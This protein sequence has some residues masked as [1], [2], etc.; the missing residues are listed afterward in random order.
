M[1]TKRH[2]LFRSLR[3]HP[4]ILATAP[5]DHAAFDDLTNGT[6]HERAA[7]LWNSDMA[8]RFPNAD[9]TGCL[10]WISLEHSVIHCPDR[11]RTS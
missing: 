8:E 7:T 9:H 5:D 11:P 4:G 3:R 1:F 10:C 2:K 6:V